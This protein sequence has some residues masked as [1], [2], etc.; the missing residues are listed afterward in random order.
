METNQE[1]AVGA[2][3]RR[4]IHVHV[5]SIMGAFI[6]AVYMNLLGDQPRWNTVSEAVQ[7]PSTTDNAQFQL[8][9]SHIGHLSKQP[10][11]AFYVDMEGVGM[12]RRSGDV[13]R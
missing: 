8:P 10:F 2:R 7:S 3:T 9:P 13:Q 12:R 6:T 5:H 1:R 4:A 11:R